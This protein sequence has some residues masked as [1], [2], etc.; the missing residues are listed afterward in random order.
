VSGLIESNHKHSPI[1]ES[2]VAHSCAALDA[3]GGIS[4]DGCS[5]ADTRNLHGA[6][7]ARNT[8]LNLLGQVLPLLAGVVL[9]PYVVRGLGPDRF[10]LLGIVWVLFG[11]LSLMDFGLGRATTKFVAECLA[12]DETKRISEMFWSS[13]ILQLMFGIVGGIIICLLTPT[14]VEQIFKT[15]APIINEARYGFY[16]LAVSLPFVVMANGLRSTLEGCQRFDIT[17]LIRVPANVVGFAIPALGVAVG[18][19]LPAIVLGM[20]ISRLIF[21]VVHG[22]YCVRILPCL[23]TR[24]ALSKKVTASLLS[25]GGWVTVA[26]TIN[27]LLVSMDRFL[28]GSFVSTAMVGYY[29][30]PFEAVTKLWIFPASLTTTVYPACSALGSERHGDLQELYSRTIKYIYCVLAPITVILVVFAR[31]IIRIWLGPD[32]VDK[33]T[34]PLQVLAIGVFVNCFAHVPYCFLQ[35]RGRPDTAAKL[36]LYELAPYSVIAWYLITS[37]GIDGAAIAW[38]IRVFVEA[39]LYLWIARRTLSLSA[40]QLTERRVSRALIVI[41]ATGIA[42]CATNHFL[43]GPLPV[44]SLVG[45]WLTLFC[46][47]VWKRILDGRDRASVVAMLRP[48]WRV[49]FGNTRVAAEG[50]P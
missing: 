27:P 44:S 35:A 42:V 29:T 23:K 48:A 21:A 41:T 37:Y 14:L 2:P 39:L 12:K 46:V 36:V 17:N 18:W 50:E 32:F 20:G 11:Y 5:L 28:I 38:S 49:L 47:I 6:R 34:F 40:S 9:I 30:A 16:M 24:P 45:A 43:S 13:M 19:K 3:G 31:P 25:F 15:P 10:G 4:D 7:I 22:F 26:N 33:S 1:I 8:S